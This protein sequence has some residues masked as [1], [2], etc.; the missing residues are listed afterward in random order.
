MCQ[1][2]TELEEIKPGS[3]VLNHGRIKILMRKILK[4]KFPNNTCIINKLLYKI[5]HIKPTLT[6]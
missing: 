5:V 6:S 1:R 4:R 3:E 2:E